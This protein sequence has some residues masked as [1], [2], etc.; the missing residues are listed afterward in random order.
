M[1]EDCDDPIASLNMAFAPAIESAIPWA[2]V[3]GNHDQ[4]GNLS[5][6][7]LMSYITTMP[8]CVATLNPTNPIDGYGNYVLQILGPPGSPLQDKS[9]MNLYFVDSGDYSALAPNVRGYGWIHE[10]QSAWVKE[11]GKKLRGEREGAPGLAYFHIPVPEFGN[12]A[13]GEFSGGVKQEAISCARVNSGFFTTLL[14]G[15]DVKA[16]FVGHDHVND[17]CGDVHGE[18]WSV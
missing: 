8:H 10:T 18:C 15:G 13:P 4:E 11:V 14:E 1:Q 5:R 9:V 6:A 3:L 17:F 16:A 7:N 2:A 12:L